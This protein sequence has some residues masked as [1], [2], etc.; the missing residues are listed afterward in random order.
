MRLE[1]P[2]EFTC[3]ECGVKWTEM[4]SP[5]DDWYKL[6]THQTLCDKCSIAAIKKAKG[7]WRNE[8][9]SRRPSSN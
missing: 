5:D 3:P 4:Q 8:I 2:V 1:V 6:A 9:L 7:D